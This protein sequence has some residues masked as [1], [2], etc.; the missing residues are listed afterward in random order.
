MIYMFVGGKVEL[1]DNCEYGKVN[2]DVMSDLVILFKD[3]LVE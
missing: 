2:I 3:M 1:V